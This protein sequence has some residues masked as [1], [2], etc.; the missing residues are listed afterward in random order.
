VGAQRAPAVRRYSTS[1]FKYAR[2]ADREGV[3]N[4]LA[5]QEASRRPF[6]DKAKTRQCTNARPN[7]R[8]P[9]RGRHCPESVVQSARVSI[10]STYSLWSTCSSGLPHP[11]WPER[12]RRLM[13]RACEPHSVDC[14]AQNRQHT[15]PQSEYAH[16]AT[17]TAKLDALAHPL[18]VALCRRKPLQAIPSA[19]PANPLAGRKLAP[20]SSARVHH[21]SCTPARARGA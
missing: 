1:T 4:W 6:W 19:Q 14:P 20:V 9:R 7:R 11:E 3:N 5:R 13:F 12:V 8:K 17:D 16:R 10:L 2:A 21:R 15:C 18:L